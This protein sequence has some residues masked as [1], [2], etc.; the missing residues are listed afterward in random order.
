MRERDQYCDFSEHLQLNIGCPCEMAAAMT[1][2]NFFSRTRTSHGN[3]SDFSLM[4]RKLKSNLNFN[5][6]DPI[7]S[8]EPPHVRFIRMLEMDPFMINHIMNICILGKNI[9]NEI[10][11]GLTNF[12]S[13]TLSVALQKIS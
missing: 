13:T 7:I 4:S 5:Q 11:V 10:S 6:I 12:I 9:N 3:A 2:I 8:C 1:R